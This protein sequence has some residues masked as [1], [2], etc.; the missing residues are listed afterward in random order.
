MRPTGGKASAIVFDYDGTLID[1]ME[2]K[3]ASY[4]HS[5]EAVFCTP[6]QTRARILASHRKTSGAHRFVQLDDTLAILG[7]TATAEQRERWNE[8][9]ASLNREGLKGVTLFPS[10]KNTLHTLREKGFALYAVSGIPEEE[11]LA[12]LKDKG[13]SDFFVE[14]R[15]GDK[16]EFL[17]SLKGR[18][19]RILLFAGDTPF[20][21]R[22]A[23]EAGVPFYRVRNDRDI[24]TL[25][26]FIEIRGETG[27]GR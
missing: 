3:A 15:G 6:P 8:L 27:D 24:R 25:P 21:E 23:G 13:L 26:A 11:F 14:A 5:V 7:L 18:G 22:A 16:S 12:E 4:L 17:R 19:I 20:D 2:T 1:T 10:V 9:Y